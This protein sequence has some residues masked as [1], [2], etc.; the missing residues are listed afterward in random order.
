LPSKRIEFKIGEASIEVEVSNSMEFEKEIQD[1]RKIAAIIKEKL[2][3]ISLK[4]ILVKPN[5]V[6]LFESDRKYLTFVGKTPDKRNEQVMLAVYGYGLDGASVE[7]IE[8]TT[9]IFDVTHNVIGSGNNKHYFKR[10]GKNKYKLSKDGEDA[11]E[12]QILPKL[13]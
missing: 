12:N 9:G 8:T 13:K 4:P 6:G 7:Q 11:V 3:D 2:E 10:V 1:V 5:L